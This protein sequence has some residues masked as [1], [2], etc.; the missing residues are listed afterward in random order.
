MYQSH[1]ECVKSMFYC[2]KKNKMSILSHCNDEKPKVKWLKVTFVVNRLVPWFR[3]VLF[4][5]VTDVSKLALRRFGK[6]WRE[7]RWFLQYVVKCFGIEKNLKE[8]NK[9]VFSLNVK[10]ENIIK[11]KIRKRAETKY[12]IY[13]SVE[14]KKGFKFRSSLRN[15]ASFANLFLWLSSKKN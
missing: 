7:K 13:F 5:A 4:S 8:T 12:K 10:S 11:I 2:R 14:L 1:F 9:H 6:I 15:M 3:F